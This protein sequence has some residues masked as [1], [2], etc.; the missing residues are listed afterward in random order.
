MLGVV[1]CPL[2]TVKELLPVDSWAEFDLGLP[3]PAGEHVELFGILDGGE[4][5]FRSC[6]ILVLSFSK[7]VDCVDN[8][9]RGKEVLPELP[10]DSPK[11]APVLDWG[12]VGTTPPSKGLE[13]LGHGW[14]QV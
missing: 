1:A 9:I 3:T 8:S 7:P 5:P 11:D 14:R 2:D 12:K 13:L 4:S 6:L 10:N